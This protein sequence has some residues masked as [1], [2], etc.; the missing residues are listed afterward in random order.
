MALKAAPET[1]FLPAPSAASLP[2]VGTWQGGLVQALARLF[3]D[4]AYR[5]NRT[6]PKDGSEAMT[7]PLVLATFT[8]A[9]R[10]A[11][12]SW[13]GGIIFVSDG[14]AGAVFQGSNGS[15]WVNLG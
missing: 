6:L 4:V 2:A 14:G 1:P 3:H 12:A 7:Q 10:P 5:V 13:A 9:T 15:T 11:A 8:V